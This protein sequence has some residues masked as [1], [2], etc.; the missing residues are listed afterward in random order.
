MKRK[1]DY[2]EFL[3]KPA[4]E[5]NVWFF[6][7]LD[8]K[9]QESVRVEHKLKSN[10]LK[11]YSSVKN[12]FLTSKKKKSIK[13][14]KRIV[15]G[16]ELKKEKS[17]FKDIEDNN[18]AIKAEY[19]TRA[20]ELKLEGH[21]KEV[22]TE[23]LVNEYSLS[24]SIADAAVRVAYDELAKNV[25][26][27]TIQLLLLDHQRNYDSLYK[28]FME[29]DSQTLA[30]AALRNKERLNGVGNDI[31][32]IQINNLIE[33]VDQR[34]FST[35][36]VNLLSTDEKKHLRRLIS[37]FQNEKTLD[38]LENDETKTFDIDE[39]F[40]FEL[41]KFIYKKSY[42]EFFK[43]AFKVLHQ[44][45]QYNDNWHIEYLC[46]RL[47]EE[48]LRIAQRK[49]RKK[50][51]IINIPFRSAKSMIASIIFP[52]WCW[53]T[54]P[55]RKF[56]YVSYAESLAL[57]HAQ[58]S[59]N[60]INS[61][62]FQ[63]LF[64]DSFKIKHDENSKEFYANTAGG[65]RK[66]VGTGGQITG[67]GADIIICDDPQ[68]PKRAA[69]EKER[70]NTIDFYNH[71]LYSRLN[72]PDIGVRIVI[73]QRLHERDLAGEL[74]ETNA[75]DYEL[76]KIPAEITEKSKPVP[77]TLSSFYNN[78]LFWSTRFSKNVLNNYL[79]AL[80]S[81]QYAGQLQQLPAPEEGNIMKRDWFEVVKGESVSRDINLEP[82]HFYLDTAETEKQ[83][84]DFTAIVSC[85]KRDNQLY[86][87]DV[88][89][90]QKEFYKNCAF[91]K[92]YVYRLKYSK[93]S[94]IKVE[95]KSSG[96]SIVSQLRA[97]TQ[98]NVMELKAPVDDKLTRVKSCQP[99]CES[100]R[101]SLI[102]GAY[103][104]KFLDQ[105]C[106]FPNASHDDMVDAFIHAVEDLLLGDD[107]DFIFI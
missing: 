96:K 85:F 98:L 33:E 7:Y 71:T 67:S 2:L 52:V 13:K 39:H 35:Y 26:D 24:V 91:I 22:I 94:K 3:S 81:V 69:S 18:R 107:F 74:I 48:A 99:I 11:L 40:E 54:Y 32:E 23:T 29:N 64:G 95:P 77:D 80:G 84:G 83:E 106:T 5:N 19:I 78:G 9:T 102:E 101:V 4:F 97:T 17:N 75:D 38:D 73:Q 25:D 6:T 61:S 30:I 45:G 62:W 103:V 59:K 105:L 10:I 57:E 70:Q 12:K 60:L 63:T 65:F 104:D 72:E 31:F 50:D 44:D 47:Q 55:S 58:F 92:D 82:I 51:I 36:N 46:D 16:R 15:S 90:Y 87:V 49:P 34:V 8:P 89:E 27:E 100:R 21:L 28:K 93:N 76:I 20:L 68:N 86:I 88:I 79:K 41:K 66:S 1:I 43:E 56:I 53:I 14:N 42:Y 37:S